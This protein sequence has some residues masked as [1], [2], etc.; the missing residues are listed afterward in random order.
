MVTQHSMPGAGELR[1]WNFRYLWRYEGL[2]PDIE[3][4]AVMKQGE[5]LIQHLLGNVRCRVELGDYGFDHFEHDVVLEGV[6]ISER[7]PWS[8]K[9]ISR[10]LGCG[11]S[12]IS[13]EMYRKF[14]D[15]I[16]DISSNIVFRGL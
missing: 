11:R 12:S 16:S 13:F 8:A 15:K 7:P 9:A 10:Y 6:S 14:R 4:F 5:I 2:G 3:G 1:G